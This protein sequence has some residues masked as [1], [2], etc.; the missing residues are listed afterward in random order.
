MIL[1]SE[2]QDFKIINNVYCISGS[3]RENG[4][5]GREA[6]TAAVREQDI[7]DATG[8]EVCAGNQ[9]IF[10]PPWE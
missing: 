8:R 10:S 3:R 5:G 7:Q 6:P 1:A 9:V 2:M 4:T